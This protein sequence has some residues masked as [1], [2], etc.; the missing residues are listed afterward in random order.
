MTKK[1]SLAL[2]FYIYHTMERI[3]RK[4]PNYLFLLVLLLL[5]PLGSVSWF[6]NNLTTFLGEEEKGHKFV[7]SK[8]M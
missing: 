5:F 7:T 3:Y 6:K 2:S 4:P 1:V 8:K